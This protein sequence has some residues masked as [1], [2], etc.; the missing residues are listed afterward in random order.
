MILDPNKPMK[1]FAQSWADRLKELREYGRLDSTL[2]PGFKRDHMVAWWKEFDR[3]ARDGEQMSR[4]VWHSASNTVGATWDRMW[5]GALR[6]RNRAA[7]AHRA[8]FP[9][10]S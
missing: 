3:R 9:L 7:M 6:V 8:Q 5:V 2:V 4:H 1:T 10:P